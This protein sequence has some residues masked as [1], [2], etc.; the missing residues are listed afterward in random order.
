MV[1]SRIF[2]KGNFEMVKTKQMKLAE[3]F[4]AGKEYTSKQIT[5]RFGLANPTAAVNNVR[6]RNGLRVNT[7]T[8]TNSKGHTSTVYTMKRS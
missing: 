8:R 2:N 4:K 7:V 3:A 5:A 6:V 1:P